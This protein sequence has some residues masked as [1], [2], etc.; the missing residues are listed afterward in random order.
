MLALGF[1]AW[2]YYFAPQFA[3]QEVSAI[4]ENITAKKNELNTLDTERENLNR[5][6]FDTQSEIRQDLY[7]NNISVRRQ[8]PAAE[9]SF[10]AVYFLDAQTGWAVGIG[11]AI[12][13]TA[14][15][16][17]TWTAP[18]SGT[19]E[20]LYSV[21]FADAQTGWAVGT[22][23]AIRATAD[24]GR[25]WI[26]Q[27]SGTNESLWS[28]HFVDTSRGW[29]AGEGG[30]VLAVSAIYLAD[31]DA[32]STPAAV[33]DF[34]RDE[35]TAQ[36]I[37][38]DDYTARMQAIGNDMS[39]TA[40]RIASIS[41]EIST[42]NLVAGVAQNSSGESANPYLLISTYANR[43]GVILVILF[44]VGILVSLY[45]YN[46]RLSAFYDARADALY[47][48]DFLDVGFDRLAEALTPDTVDFGKQPRSPVDQVST[49][50][51]ELI[52]TR[53]PR[54]SA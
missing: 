8:L 41:S 32:L 38:A 23:G 31:F 29:I 24:G 13:A 12:R 45:R 14:D 10:I 37:D 22:G 3:V 44:L 40:T 43:V 16:G 51:R 18:D 7:I 15:G 39:V 27:D 36:Q 53:G 48:M 35:S 54:G 4:G 6:F 47:M 42:L 52:R 9:P 2:F 50:A 30:T 11:G 25:T 1:A 33:I 19:N 17:R 49:L 46:M 34:L 5:T 28:V 20:H 26:Q 21:H